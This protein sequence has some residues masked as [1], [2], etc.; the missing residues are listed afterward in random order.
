[1]SFFSGLR[2]HSLT[3][4]TLR[5][6][7]I[8]ISIIIA[9]TAVL[10]YLHI[11]R[12]IQKSALQSLELY[13]HERALRER[14]IFK[15]AQDNHQV[16]REALVQVFRKIE[17]SKDDPAEAYSA[18]V[19]KDSDGAWRSP[20]SEPGKK[21]EL[22]IWVAKTAKTSPLFRRKV[23]EFSKVLLRFGPAFHARFTDTYVALGENANLVYWPDYPDWS[24]GNAADFDFATYE[25]YYIHK[26]NP[27]RK[28]L[29]SG[30]YFDDAIKEWMV[31]ASTPIDDQ[32][33]NFS[34][35]IGHD[36][37]VGELIKRTTNEG[38]PG[39]YNILIAKDGRIIAHPKLMEAVTRAKGNLKVS[40]AGDPVLQAI[41][42]KVNTMPPEQRTGERILDHEGYDQ[43]IAVSHM[44]ETG[45]DFIIVY[46][47]SLIRKIADGTVL[48]IIGLG[49][50]SLALE[51]AVLYFIFRDKISKPLGEFIQ[52]TRDIEFGQATTPL[53]TARI[54]EIG[55]LSR[56]FDSMA[57]KIRRANETL[58]EKVEQ[59]T[60]QLQKAQKIATQNAHAAGMAEIA[61]NIL[62]NIGNTIN[63]VKLSAEELKTLLENSD[64][65]NLAKALRMIEENRAHLA[66]FLENDP[67]G[68]TLPA[69]FAELARA[70]KENREASVSTFDYLLRKIR[71][72]EEIVISQQQYVKM[73][74]FIEDVDLGEVL[75][76]CIGMLN[77]GSGPIR[78]LTHFESV[79]PIRAQRV[80]VMQII[81][82][83]LKNALDSVI[84]KG[85]QGAQ[86]IEICLYEESK[87][88]VVSIRDTGV[89]IPPENLDKIFSHGFTT[90]AM[91][92]GF[93]L[94][95]CALAVREL[96][97]SLKVTSD[98]KNT[99]FTL[100]I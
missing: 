3:H 37:M 66:D 4:T 18:L 78:L 29:W 73:G 25:L 100:R 26:N 20:P 11:N 40:E 30:V 42:D 82:N 21:K 46:P 10:T 55:V 32:H 94:H 24:A 86:E 5:A 50:L 68:K 95:F 14:Q 67:K 13:M 49:L 96:G 58:L 97:G 9:L 99:T 51:L 36:V 83:L 22:D 72:I 64:S 28:T 54:D 80:K 16:M 2:G 33:G 39:T 38:L 84:E 70:T 52:A 93:G 57:M 90:K 35:I 81:L 79:H 8:R 44:P 98:A 77:L 69:Y 48:F 87:D 92:H 45:W 62:H 61:T 19:R 53:Q 41:Y 65:K 47:K 15:L 76:E 59:R 85:P 17:N 74:S 63:S 89:G 6:V 12:Q 23:V 43:F 71:V 88:T 7:A 91:G 31:S 60:S 75:K 1:M 34:T 56:S 27:E